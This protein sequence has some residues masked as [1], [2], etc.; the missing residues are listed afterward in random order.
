MRLSGTSSA[1][2][3]LRLRDD[4]R[5]LPDR[6]RARLGDRLAPR[7]RRARAR[8]SA[9]AS[10]SS[11]TRLLLAPGLRASWTSCPGSREACEPARR[12]SAC[13]TRA[14]CAAT[15]LLPAT[16]VHR[17]DLPVRGARRCARRRRRGR[18]RERARLR[19]EHGRRDRR[20]RWARASSLIPALGF[21]GTLVGAA[22]TEPARSRW[23]SAR[24][25]APRARWLPL[26]ALAGGCGAR[27]V[28]LRRATPW[29]VLR[30]H[31]SPR[32]YARAAQG[33]PVRPSLRRRAAPR[34][35]CCLD[36]A[37]S[38]RLRTNGLPE[39]AIGRAARLAAQQP[40]RALARA[41]PGARPARGRATCS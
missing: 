16:L 19:L 13:S 39:A 14:V 5:E 18:R 37:D 22:L 33:R 35:C 25:V 41:A 26:L 3:M 15:L 9:S 17:R 23:R 1:R 29:R 2:S 28:V 24:L 27:L 4:A 34:R 31:A 12:C 32:R 20:A 8:R 10:R 11:A 40:T 21:A 6:H 30:T 36:E 7:A 38:W